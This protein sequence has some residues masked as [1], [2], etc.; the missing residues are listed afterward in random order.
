[1][2]RVPVPFE[3]FR[4]ERDLWADRW[5]LS[6]HDQTFEL[7]PWL[8]GERCRLVETARL[9]G[10]FNPAV[11]FDGLFDLLLNPKPEP[12]Q[13]MM[14]GALCLYLLGVS[15]K[16]DGA[17][18]ARIEYLA[19]KNFGWRPDELAQQQAAAIERLV[20]QIEPPLTASQSALLPTLEDGWTRIVVT[21]EAGAHPQAPDSLEE[22]IERMISTVAGWAESEPAGDV[23][24]A[25]S[26]APT[27][28]PGETAAM[29]PDKPS[30]PPPVWA[31]TISGVARLHRHGLEAAGEPARNSPVEFSGHHSGSQLRADSL[32][33]AKAKLPA[34]A[35][36]NAE[37]ETGRLDT[38]SLVAAAQ[39]NRPKWNSERVNHPAQG[40]RSGRHSPPD[41]T[42]PVPASRAQ[43]MGQAEKANSAG[44]LANLNSGDVPSAFRVQM[45]WPESSSADD[46]VSGTRVESFP[47][48]P[49]FSL[50]EFEEQMADALE[51][52]ALEAGVDLL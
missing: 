37:T 18:L 43:V 7:R 41:R 47:N 17:S 22:R 16:S 4:V 14:L 24:A 26:T 32:L 49:F 31:P 21:Q 38:G 25:V 46:A 2:I 50:G 15:E 28:R 34:E 20:A 35:P 27:E 11:F 40:S 13:A 52:A 51:R 39:P 5:W 29:E 30:P 3:E 10:Q 48:P 6:V 42:P 36:E 1:M 23:L 45:T 19:V 33:R 9:G 12:A 8:W 44:P